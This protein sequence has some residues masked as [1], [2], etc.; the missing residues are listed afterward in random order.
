LI[1]FIE[2]LPFF[3]DTTKF[4]QLVETGMHSSPSLG[5]RLYVIISYPLRLLAFE[6]IEVFLVFQ[7]SFY[8]LS[9]LLLWQG[10]LL[11]CHHYKIRAGNFQILVILA[12]LYPSALSFITI[13]LR[14]FMQV[15]G[16]SLFLYG[17]SHYIYKNSIKWLVVGALLTVFVRPQL[18][19]VYPF[20]ILIAKQ[21]SFLKLF[22]YGLSALPVAVFLFENVTGY[23][24]SPS[25][26]SYLRNAANDNFGDSGMTYGI[27]N[28]QTYFDIIFD[29][30]LLV[31]QFLLSPL[32]ILHSVNPLNL[33]LLLVDVVF[34]FVILLGAFS[35]KMRFSKFYLKMFICLITIFSIC[36][37][38]IGGA[39]RHR[40]PL[41]MMLL[42]LASLFYSEKLSILLRKNKNVKTK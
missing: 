25:F 39:V 35:V 41:I 17:L 10:W 3:P 22:I 36:E 40:F 13:P 32:P 1:T 7:V 21:Y 23:Q 12:V 20:L 19:V 15:F 42:P 34:V 5:V 30:P 24:F 2:I 31:L 18:V 29:L 14:E 16:F 6:Q 37:F 27:V 4:A 33:K 26:F 11:H 28:W 38:Y 9:I 8:F